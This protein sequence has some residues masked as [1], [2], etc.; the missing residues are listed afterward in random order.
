MMAE[1]GNDIVEGMLRK[2]GSI[3]FMWQNVHL[4]GS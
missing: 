1:Q 4:G 3:K 2:L